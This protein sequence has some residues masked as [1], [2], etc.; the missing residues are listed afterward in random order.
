MR[1]NTL[2]LILKKLK[3]SKN[4]LLFCLKNW[5]NHK[6]KA[7]VVESFL[8]IT[9]P[10]LLKK[11]EEF[12]LD[13]QKTSAGDNI[14]KWSDVAKLYQKIHFPKTKKFVL[15][16]CQNKGG[17]GKTTTTINMGYLFS[18][19]GKTL[20][21]DLDAQANLSQSFEIYKSKGDFSLKDILENPKDVSSGVINVYENLDI[22]PNT[23]SFDIWKRTANN[24]RSPQYLLQKALKN[25]K[26]NYDFIIIDCPP[27][28]D[29]AFDLALYSSDYALVILEPHPFSI[30]NLE[31]II[32][33]IKRIIDDDVTG[34]LNLKILGA[35]F[36]R[37][38]DTVITRE[39][40]QEAEKNFNVFNTKIRDNIQI[41]E[42]QASKQPVF[43]Y[44]ESCNGSNDYF[45]L[46]IELMEKING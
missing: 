22:I 19:I 18:C 3:F 13:I 36:S 23:T 24:K 11:I 25:I 30:E 7:G 27:A 4:R 42:S 39:I 17:V 14:F 10:T 44:N 16:M 21:V 37:Y 1:H 6:M 41:P 9:R 5:L 45:S 15:S 40:V 2:Y 46:W 8:K 26:D 35:F 20:L 34:L 43:L 31:N 33:E 28:M 32:T 38:K 12:S 29:I